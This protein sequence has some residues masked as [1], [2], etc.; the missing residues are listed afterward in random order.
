M[1]GSSKQNALTIKIREKIEAI[2]KPNT[3][4]KVFVPTTLSASASRISFVVVPP[5]RK[6][7]ATLP[8]AIGRGSNGFPK[9]LQEPMIAKKPRGRATQT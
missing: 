8:I 2:F 3:F 5:K 6:R 4:T 9:T 1:Q 7:A